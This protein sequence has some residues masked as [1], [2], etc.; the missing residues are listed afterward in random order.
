MSESFLLKAEDGTDLFVYRWAPNAAPRAVVQIAHGAAEHA[1]R[2]ARLARVLTE[3]GY[4]VYANDHRGHGKTAG[5]AERAGIV[6]PDGWN[7][8]VRDA[9]LLTDHLRAVHDGLPIVLLGHSMGSMLA[10]QYIQHWGSGLDGV[11]LS[12]TASAL[13]PGAE[14]LSERVAA[15]IVREGADAPSMDFAMLFA[16]F[17]EPFVS[18]AAEPGP[19]G[20]EWLSR[21]QGEV[22]RYV[23]DPWCGFPFSNGLVGDFAPGLERLW[24]PGTESTIPKDL[25]VLIIAGDQDPVGECGESVH[26]LTERYRAAGL[27]VDEILYPGARHEIF[28]ETNRDEVHTDVLRWL[29]KTCGPIATPSGA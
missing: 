27:D 7:T 10:Q 25:P 28:N 21:D 23:D 16:E 17:N 29:E 24:A 5:S 9:K 13:Q 6:G 4:V 3:A 12:G 18:G 19:T 15:A 2:Y 8:I 26:R 11:I 14:G 20:F 1:W 22:Q